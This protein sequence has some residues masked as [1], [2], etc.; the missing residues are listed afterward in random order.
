MPHRL[1]PITV[2]AAS[3]S[4]PAPVRSASASPAGFPWE[5]TIAIAVVALL[6]LGGWVAGYV[7]PHPHLRAASSFHLRPRRT[8]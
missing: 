7:W 8:A 2:A 3:G 1:S 6:W 4:A 5:Q